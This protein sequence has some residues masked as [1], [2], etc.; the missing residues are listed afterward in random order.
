MHKRA[1]PFTYRQTGGL[2]KQPGLPRI[3][4]LLDPEAWTYLT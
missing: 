4:D 1:N 2:E 3:K